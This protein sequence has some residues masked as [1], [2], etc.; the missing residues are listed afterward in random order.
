MLII[1]ISCIFLGAL[2]GFLAGLLGIDGGLIV[3]P[4][5]VY[6]L[7][8]LT[9]VNDVMGQGALDNEVI[10]PMALATSLAASLESWLHL[11]TCFIRN[12]ANV[13]L[14]CSYWG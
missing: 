13:L 7:P 9:V 2:V 3:V 10:M 1:F 8:Y 14:I 12:C 4:A 5:L 6:L 11:F